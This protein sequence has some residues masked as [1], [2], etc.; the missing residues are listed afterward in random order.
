[1]SYINRSYGNRGY[2]QRGFSR[3]E[4]VEEGKEY[5]AD[6]TELSRRGDGMAKIEGSVISV[7]GAKTRDHVKFRVTRV[8]RRF[9][10][11]EIVQRQD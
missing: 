4:P 1:M 11:A 8:A 9:A 2:S 7:S 6:I 3:R 5:E 10:A